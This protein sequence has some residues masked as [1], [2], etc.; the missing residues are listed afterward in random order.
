[1]TS[2]KQLG[3]KMR[4]LSLQDS[5]KFSHLKFLLSYPR[6]SYFHFFKISLINHKLL[7]KTAIRENLYAQNNFLMLKTI[8][9]W[10][11]LLNVHVPT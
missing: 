10:V 11:L 9:K 1:M 2:P 8:P 4:N 5:W 3:H 7:G 6:A